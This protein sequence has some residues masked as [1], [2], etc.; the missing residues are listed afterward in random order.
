[1]RTIDSH[2]TLGNDA[3]QCRHEAVRIHGHR[4][5]RA[6]ADGALAHLSALLLAERE[7][8]PGLEPARA[9]V[10]LGGLVV[11]CEGMTRYGLKEI[12]ASERDILHGAVLAAVATVS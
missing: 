10:I 7:R 5:S 9:P 6:T 11:L 12:E 4:M 2:E 3:V 1:M 8:V